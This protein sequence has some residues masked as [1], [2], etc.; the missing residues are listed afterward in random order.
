MAEGVSIVLAV[1]GYQPPHQGIYLY[2]IFKAVLPGVKGV[3]EGATREA[4]GR[5][6]DAR[7]RALL[8]QRAARLDGVSGVTLQQ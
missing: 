5:S 3:H 7:V 8:P 2:K 4:D 6:E 1:G